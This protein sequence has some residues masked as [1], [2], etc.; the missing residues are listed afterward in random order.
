MRKNKSSRPTLRRGFTLIELLVV[1]AIIAILIALLVPA[2]QKVREAAS[3]THC[4]NNLK[5]IA[6]ALHSYHDA[7]G[8]LPPGMNVD[9]TKH[10]GGDCRGTPLWVLLLPYLEEENLYKQYDQNLQW[11]SNGAVGGHPMP[12]YIC[13][14]EGLWSAY[15]TRRTYYGVVGGKVNFGHGLRGDVFTDG[16]FNINIFVRLT[17]IR[18]GSS[19]TLAIGESIHPALYGLGPGYGIAT[20]GGPAGW[21]LSNGCSAP[22]CGLANRS[23][24]RDLRGTK[25]PLRSSILPMTP[26]EENE[27]PFG[28]AHP[29]GTQ[30][31][32]ADGRVVFL[33]DA[34]SMTTYQSL[35]SYNLDDAAE[36][37]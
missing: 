15:P 13:P 31:A 22:S 9:V 14:S 25:Y 3:R 10:C 19:N 34:I 12:I 18:D 20:E 35:G 23:L 8:R 36:A 7:K 33:N 24:G 37:P 32:C 26:D 6:L 5:Q 2:V 30:F 17:D 21:L 16:L 29:G 27:S 1:I 28:S 11:G 4:A